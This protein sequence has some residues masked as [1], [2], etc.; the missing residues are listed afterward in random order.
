MTP[1]LVATKVPTITAVGVASPKA[2][3]HATTKVDMP[4]FKANS[5]FDR[6]PNIKIY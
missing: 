4:K 1:N 5:N 3:G 2:Q 6:S